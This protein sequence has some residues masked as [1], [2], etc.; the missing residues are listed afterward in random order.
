[1]VDV[2]F[3]KID[4]QSKDQLD[5]V[6]AQ[7]KE[8]GGLDYVPRERTPQ[9]RVFEHASDCR[10]LLKHLQRLKG[11]H[12]TQ[13]VSP[14]LYIRINHDNQDVQDSSKATQDDKSVLISFSKTFIDLTLNANGKADLYFHAY[15]WLILI[16]SL[17]ER[18]NAGSVD[19]FEEKIVNSSVEVLRLKG[20]A[21]SLK[22]VAAN[23]SKYPFNKEIY[24]RFVNDLGGRKQVK[25]LK[26]LEDI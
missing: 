20:L 13:K 19:G 8:K 1:M 24:E 17:Y 2:D 22:K 10:V 11:E 18:S 6:L 26:Y 12:D 16:E 23:L 5:Q 25:K 4:G 7:L 21:E 14:L 15:I 9:G 3:S